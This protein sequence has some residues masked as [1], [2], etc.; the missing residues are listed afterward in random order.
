MQMPTT[1]GAFRW[2]QPALLVVL[3]A[4]LAGCASGPTTTRPAR[5]GAEA[6][7]PPDL[8]RVPDAE[9]RLEPIRSGGPNK[10]YAVLGRDY[11]PIT[12]DAPFTERGI[13]SWYGRKFHGRRT[14]SGEVYNMYAMTGA[15]P[16]LPIPSYARVRN[17]ANGREVV[18]RINDRGPFHPG[19]IVDL[20]YTAAL[21]LDLLRGVGPVELQ[22]ITFDEI[23]TG[24]WRRDGDPAR[25]AEANAPA[26]AVV[27]APAAVEPEAPAPP[28]EANIA[29]AAPAPAADTSPVAD[30]PAARAYTRPARGFWVQLGAFTQ[31]DGAEGFHKRV[32]S[33]AD[34]LAPLL[35]VFSDASVF[36]LQAGPYPSR[37]EARGVAERVRAALQLVPV[38]VER[39]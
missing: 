19:R 36:R 25:L 1:S 5:D 11:T 16:T 37:E 38:I 27:A 31:R 33:E 10:P 21:K 24:A 20:S 2:P 9:P 35:A 13:A 32:S 30:A 26:P 14:A 7:P 39:R 23:R 8:A 28:P 29:A 15:H 18:L 4:V 22:R 34:W 3:A 12:K 17:P 6:N